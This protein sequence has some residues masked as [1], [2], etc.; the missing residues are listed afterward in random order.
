MFELDK[1][2]ESLNYHYG[3]FVPIFCRLLLILY[4]VISV[5][6]VGNVSAINGSAIITGVG[7]SFNTFFNIGDSI[8]ISSV[9]YS[10]QS[11]QSGTQL[12]LTTPYTGLTAG[13]L[14]YKRNNIVSDL[15]ISV[16]FASKRFFVTLELEYY[17]SDEK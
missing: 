16:Y 13:G 7:T 14:T 3:I 12:T 1:F 5:N 15:S 11:I 6:G 10:I 9:K 4:S 2:M 8:E 17:A